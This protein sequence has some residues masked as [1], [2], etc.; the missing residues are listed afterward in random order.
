M[1]EI[2]ELCESW[3]SGQVTHGDLV[4]PMSFILS[5]IAL[6]GPD[7]NLIRSVESVKLKEVYEWPD[8][9][10]RVHQIIRHHEYHWFRGYP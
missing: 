4:N 1:N 7:S 10:P 6:I 9:S 8:S 2:N 3:V 5:L